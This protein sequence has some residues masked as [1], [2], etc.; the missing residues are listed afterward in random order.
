MPKFSYEKKEK[1]KDEGSYKWESF[2]WEI[3][4]T[5]SPI[6]HQGCISSRPRGDMMRVVWMR[7]L[8]EK[9]GLGLFW[10]TRYIQYTQLGYLCQRYTWFGWVWTMD[11]DFGCDVWMTLYNTRYGMEAKDM[12]MREGGRDVGWKLWM[13]SM[14]WNLGWWMRSMFFSESQDGWELWVRSMLE[15]LGW[16]QIMDERSK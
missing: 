11:E 8:D 7:I 2:G 3:W 10:M 15:D 1:K 9:F 6:I 13:R 14:F 4:M 5:H 16:M 12:I